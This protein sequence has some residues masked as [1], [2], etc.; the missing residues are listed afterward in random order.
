MRRR[1]DNL[2][3]YNRY[4]RYKKRW[5]PSRTK[6]RLILYYRNPLQSRRHLNRRLIALLP[7]PFLDRIQTHPPDF[8]PLSRNLQHSNL[9]H[10]RIITAR[11]RSSNQD[12][13]TL[14]NFPRTLVLLIFN[15]QALVITR[16]HSSP[17][18]RQAQVIIPNQWR[19][20]CP[21]Y[22][23]PH[24]RC[25]NTPVRPHL[26]ALNIP[27]TARIIRHTPIPCNLQTYHL[28]SPLSYI[29]HHGRQLGGLWSLIWIA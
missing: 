27:P 29:N 18:Q 28:T 23:K 8:H 20:Q 14:H 12:R 1:T 7:V 6:S 17:G 9:Q 10:K 3:D 15:L 2:H 19:T 26:P 16:P 24:Q 11:I 21:N 25:T 4:R 22:R 5:E 13:G